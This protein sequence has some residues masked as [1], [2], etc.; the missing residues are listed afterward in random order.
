MA[1]KQKFEEAPDAQDE[2]LGAQ[3]EVLSTE[4]STEE[5]LLLAA[6]DNN[7][8]ESL[9]GDENISDKLNNLLTIYLA[10]ANAIGKEAPATQEAFNNLTTFKSDKVKI[11]KVKVAKEKTFNE[12]KVIRD[13]IVTSVLNGDES[14]LSALKEL[15]EDERI[16]PELNIAITT[17]MALVES[18]NIPE[19]IIASTFDK[20]RTWGRKGNKISTGERKPIV[21]QPSHIIEYAGENYAN[22]SDALRAAGYDNKD[23]DK[24]SESSKAWNKAWN[25]AWST[26]NT[27]IKKN[28]VADYEDHT[29]TRYFNE[30]L[31]TE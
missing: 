11:K 4:V 3:D 26:V 20:L 6:F 10:L 23:S 30:E 27:T 18:P 14:A 1:K 31:E 2:I 7:D 17:Y 22:L 8:L 24:T 16:S 13:V 25:K 21:L 9:Q 29:F 15:L 12:G 28:G 19:P 5:S